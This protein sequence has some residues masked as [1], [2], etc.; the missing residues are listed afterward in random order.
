MQFIQKPDGGCEIKFSL[1]ERWILF[2]KGK[3]ILSP[4]ALRHFSNNLMKIVNEFYM[5]FPEDVKK[6]F[7]DVKD[8]MEGE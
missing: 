6:T 4:I 7:T 2:R 3:L 1:K 8:K 5:N